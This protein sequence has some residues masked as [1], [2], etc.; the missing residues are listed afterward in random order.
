[1][2]NL[3]RAEDCP[4]GT[5]QFYPGKKTRNN[6]TGTHLS[7]DEYADKVISDWVKHFEDKER[8]KSA[9]WSN[10]ASYLLEY[11][12]PL[13]IGYKAAKSKLLNVERK[14]AVEEE[15]EDLTRSLSTH[16]KEMDIDTNEITEYSDSHRV[17]KDFEIDKLMT[18]SDRE[19]FEDGLEVPDYLQNSRRFKKRQKEYFLGLEYEKFLEK[20]DA[21][22]PNIKGLVEFKQKHN[23]YAERFMD[24]NF[25]QS[26]SQEILI[27]LPETPSA[28]VNSEALNNRLCHLSFEDRSERLLLQNVKETIEELNKTPEGRKQA[29]E[30]IAGVSHQVYGDPGLGLSRR[31]KE[32]VKQMK[33]KLLS[34]EK[35]TLVCENF[36]KRKIFPPSIELMAKTHWTDNTIPEPAKHTGRA[37]EE[38]GETVPTR[39]QDRTNSEMYESFKEDYKG[40]VK[41]EM[42]KKAND[43][44]IQLSKRKDTEDKQ[45]RLDYANSLPEVFPSLN[46]YIAQRPRETK[47]LTDHTTGLCHLCEAAKINFTTLVKAAKVRCSCGTKHC[48]NFTCVCPI[49]DDEEEVAYCSCSGCE[50]EICTTCKVRHFFEFLIIEIQVY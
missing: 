17:A 23:L 1:M 5:A 45:R 15:G 14:I 25:A 4:S 24:D 43:M 2:S 10:K 28:I 48:A 38:E 20:Y 32:K 16:S 26:S 21:I 50:C 47:A 11:I 8:Y 34:G 3:L 36:E 39:Y 35:S 27:K 33:G 12:K 40:K 44:K 49:D 13:K 19:L 37:I 7:K 9:P 42:C 22:P 18:L 46:W 30:F 31:T 41:V 6:P 29:V